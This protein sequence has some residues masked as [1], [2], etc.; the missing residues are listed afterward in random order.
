[1]IED[2]FGLCIVKVF[3]FIVVNKDVWIYW[4]FDFEVGVVVWEDV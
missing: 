2:E 3:G 1:M 4:M